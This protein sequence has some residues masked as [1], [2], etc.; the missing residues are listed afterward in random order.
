MVYDD[1]WILIK[2]TCWHMSFQVVQ[3]LLIHPYQTMRQLVRGKVFV[4]MA[5]SP[6]LLWFL[7]LFVET[8]KVH[9]SDISRSD[10]DF[11]ALWFTVGIG[12]YQVLLMYL[13]VRFL[14]KINRPIA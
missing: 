13:L 11:L 9:F 10:L 12:M 6:V 1:R 3:G 14:F 8:S 5:C 7:S 4:W 2:P